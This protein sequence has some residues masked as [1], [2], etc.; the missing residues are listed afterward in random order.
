MAIITRGLSGGGSGS[1][2]SGTSGS[3]GTS[4][5]SGNLVSSWK[6][7]WADGTSYVIGDLVYDSTTGNVYIA[8]QNHISSTTN[9]PGVGVDWETYWSVFSS[10]GTSGTSGTS[11]S[12]GTSGVDGVD[13]VD[14]TSGSSGSSGT[15]GSSGSSG[16]SGT[17]ANIS[18]SWKGDWM[19]GSSYIIGDLVYDST[20][21]TVYVCILDHTSNTTNQPGVGVDW[22]TY[23][24]VFSGSGTSGTSGTSGSSGTSGVDG[25]M[26][27]Q[28]KLALEISL[29]FDSSNPSVRKDFTYDV[30]KNLTQIDIYTNDSTGTLL[31]TKTFTYVAKDLTQSVTT[32]ASDGATLTVTFT[33]SGKD[34]TRTESVY[35]T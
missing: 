28:E 19:D 31:F 13:G 32:R 16:S 23:W 18:S 33:Y 1:G 4:G 20:T 9:Q 30:S 8:I 22:E 12:S 10:S 6:G 15:S 34:L 5:T 2:T 25:A 35:I 17:S 14:G 27:S 3:S 7:D 26:T 21:D 24:D 29:A 11:G